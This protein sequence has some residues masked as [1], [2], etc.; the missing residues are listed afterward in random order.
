[1]LKGRNRTFDVAALPFVSLV[2]LFILFFY[3]FM[4]F[5]KVVPHCELQGV[6][7]FCFFSSNFFDL[8]KGSRLLSRHPWSNCKLLPPIL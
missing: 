3:F 5:S 7:S 6:F 8:T 4:Y 2:F 1:M